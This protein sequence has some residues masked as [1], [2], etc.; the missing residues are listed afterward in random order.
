MIRLFQLEWL[1]LRHYRPFWVLMGMFVVV[2]VL[3]TCMGVFFLEYLKR[4]GADFDGIDPTIIPIYDFP[5]VWHNMAY[6]ANIVK[7]VLGFVVVIS[8]ANEV[9]YRTLRQ[10]IIDG[11]SKKEFW[12]SKLTLVFALSA[13]GTILLFALGL[14]MGSIYSHPEAMRFMFDHLYFVWAY[15]LILVTYLTFCFWVTLLLPRVGLVIVGLF[16]YTLIFEPFLG[17]FLEN[18]PH[19]YDW[20]RSVAAF[21]PVRSLYHLIDVPFARYFLMPIQDYLRWD[22]VS[23]VV[24]WLVFNTGFS[25][26]LLRRRDW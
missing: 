22:Q 5:D 10:N 14:L 23:I 25:Y 19:L 3:S 26:Y 13:F 24:G 18:F 16:L 7:V 15:F 21:L 2:L 17:V 4:Q 12:L 6:M 1:K 9:S 8:A 20:M 11:L